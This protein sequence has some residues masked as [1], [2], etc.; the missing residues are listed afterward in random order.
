MD[1]EGWDT[2]DGMVL[3]GEKKKAACQSRNSK[4]FNMV[5]YAYA[6]IFLSRA[7]FIDRDFVDLPPAASQFGISCSLT[8]VE[9]AAIGP[10]FR[11]RALNSSGTKRRKTVST[12]IIG[13][14]AGSPLRLNHRQGA[15]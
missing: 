9:M 1:E 10:W 5:A 8:S 13:S 6:K 12:S 14:S 3:R 4:G 15:R 11:S 7:K 2:C